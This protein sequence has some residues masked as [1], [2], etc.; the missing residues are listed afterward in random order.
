MTKVFHRVKGV[1]GIGEAGGLLAAAM[2]AVASLL[3]GRT[4]LTAFGMNYGKNVIASVVLLL[5]L[6]VAAAISGRQMF[7]ANSGA[8]CWLTFSALIGI[9]AGDTFYFRSLQILGPRRALVV[10]TTSPLFAAVMGWLFL[11]EVL[12]ARCAVGILLTLC[13]VCFVSLDRKALHEAPGLFPGSVFNG[14]T[15]G[16]LGSLCNAIGAVASRH[17]MSDTDP[18]EAAFIRIAVS[19][20][21]S[22]CLVAAVGRLRVAT[23]RILNRNVLK[24]FV[25]AVLCGTWLGIWL[26][27]IAYKYSPV[28]VATTL[29][30]TT[31]IFAIPL[32]YVFLGQRVTGFGLVGTVLAVCGVWLTAL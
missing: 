9:V 10:S 20:V 11:N 30:S 1:M 14:V 16:I 26:S 17:A 19:A 8:W 13:G 2:W 22:V 28:A 21:A 29:T 4:Q 27:Q 31:P 24:W 32:V 25:P 18:V 15:L 5:H 12:T 7:S 23:V 6:G 3:Y